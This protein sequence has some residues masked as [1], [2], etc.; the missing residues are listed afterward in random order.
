[1]IAWTCAAP[2]SFLSHP[3]RMPSPRFIVSGHAG[4]SACTR[5]SKIV[6]STSLWLPGAVATAFLQRV[7]ATPFCGHYLCTTPQDAV[8]AS[9]VAKTAGSVLQQHAVHPQGS[10]LCQSACSLVRRA[11]RSRWALG[12]SVLELLAAQLVMGWVGGWGGGTVV[13]GWR[14][15]GAK[16]PH[17]PIHMDVGRY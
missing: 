2:F 8:P 16:Q 10:K 12:W 7:A 1:M 13:G 6:V 4:R 9:N 5:Q 11:E 14:C 17:L 3:L 15:G